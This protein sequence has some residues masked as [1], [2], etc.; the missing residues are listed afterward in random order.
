MTAAM[1]APEIQEAAIDGSGDD[2]LVHVACCRDGDVALC[3]EDV[4]GLEVVDDIDTPDDCVVC[5]DLNRVD[6][7]SVCPRMRGAL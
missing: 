4:T 6:C 1:A 7:C 5:D 2:G 3:G